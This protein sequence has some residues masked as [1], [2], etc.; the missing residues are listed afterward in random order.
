MAAVL[1]LTVALPLVAAMAARLAGPRWGLVSVVGGLLG[2]VPS[3]ILLV[4]AATGHQARS[5][6]AWL[7]GPGLDAGL[8]LDPL[9]ALMSCL[10]ATVGL[11]VLVYSTGYFADSARAPNVV[12]AIL[13]FLAAMQGLVL[14]DGYLA[15]LFFWELVGM[16]S[17]RLIA[18]NRDDPRAAT[19][20]VK[21]FILT[22]S[23]DFGL[24]AA[25]IALYGANGTLA[26]SSVR[27]AGALGAMVGLGLILA[28]IGK[29]AQAPLQTWLM[30]AMAGPTPVSALLHSATMVAAGVYLIVRSHALLLGW[31]LELA[32]WIGALTAVASAIIAL[33][34]SDLK[35]V[36]AA[37]TSSQ[38]GLMFVGAAAGGPAV[39]MFQ[40]VAHAMAKPALF[41]ATG[42]FQHDRGSTE[43]DHLA[44]AGR[45]DRPAFL[46]FL[47]GAATI[48]A[49]PPLALFWSKDAVAAAAQ[50]SNPAWFVL[51]LVAAA[52][53]AAYMLRPVLILG[54][55]G[56][57]PLE[58]R[59]RT[60]MLGACGV[61]A[62]G[63]VLGGLAGEPMAR[64][65]G[66]PPLPASPLSILLGIAALVVGV[67]AVLATSPP[68]W[69]RRAAARELYLPAFLDRLFRRPVFG[70][71]AISA[72][73]DDRVV[74]RAV[75]ATGRG[76]LA[77][78]RAQ[79]QIERHGVDAAVNGLA[80]LVR[81]GGERSREVQTGR[82]HEYL[83]DTIAGAAAVA[84][85]I[86]LTA[87]L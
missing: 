8:R 37:S 16:L 79:E 17:A 65:L 28:A 61:F 55:R 6:F 50:T 30:G 74:D 41:L 71:A 66:G 72:Y 32:G 63:A 56:S 34:Q 39:A 12:A 3:W 14:A 53:S 38:I 51:A 54:R 83:R 35:R 82:L 84:F 33:G 78:S 70:L 67:A 2:A 44:G 75:D 40:L 47:I 43:L 25:V 60:A 5:A 36:L 10:V 80:D 59:G 68:A 52:G 69:A 46:A 64:L 23:A 11:A 73:V 48:A 27:P 26:F 62:I 15:L 42:V 13:A 24:Y 4:E 87:L 29:S 57:G 49:V 81:R 9:S 45:S 76:A 21:A 31:P 7:P 86:A 58:P 20:A 77:I 19:G 1:W 22:R 85:V 18:W